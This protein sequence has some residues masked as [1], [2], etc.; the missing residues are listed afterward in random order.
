MLLFFVSSLI[1]IAISFIHVSYVSIFTLIILIL[2]CELCRRFFVDEFVKKISF[3]FIII[4]SGFCLGQVRVLSIDYPNADVLKNLETQKV[5]LEGVVDRETVSNGKTQ[6]IIIRTN[7]IVLSSSTI[8]VYTGVV[9]RT[10]LFPQFMYGD[11][12]VVKGTLELPDVISEEDGRTFDYQMYLFKDKITHTVSFASVRKVGEQGNFLLKGLFK[13]KKLF[14]DSIASVLPEP[15]SGLLSGILLGTDTLSKKLGD[16]FRTAG[17]SHIVV[18]SGYNITV[19]AESIFIVARNISFN[20]A[21]GSSLIGIVFFVLMSGSGA[22]VVRAGMMACIA[23]VGK[24]F[25]KKYDASRALLLAIWVMSFW[26]PFVLLYDPSFHLSVLATYG[27][28]YVSP[29]LEKYLFFIKERFGLRDLVSTTLGAQL[30][31]LPYILYMSGNFGLFSLP[32]NFLVLPLVPLTMLLGFVTSLSGFVSRFLG[33]L[34]GLPTH[35]LLSWDIFI[36]ESFAKLPFANIHVPYIP[37]FV[38]IL[39]YVVVGFFVYYLNNKNKNKK[40]NQSP[41]V[42]YS[43]DDSVVSY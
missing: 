27:L 6:K 20:F 36:A 16:D 1:G 13:I 35:L 15:Q 2:I 26:N 30:S 33:L 24:H 11:K 14:V 38:L 29:I 7:S 17:L 3:T 43:G 22:S 4:F 12:V 23:L 42:S 19:V 10:N 8:P 9:V 32:A 31:V 25:H 18:L 21:F 39:F 28:M 40:Q 34:P 5:T 41:T 37:V